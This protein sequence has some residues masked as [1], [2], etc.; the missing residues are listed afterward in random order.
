MPHIVLTEEQARILT[1]A[2]GPVE[3]LAPDGRP[4]ARAT[5]L[6]LEDMDDIDD[7]A[8]SRQSKADKGPRVPSAQVQAH[9]KR[10]EEIDRAEP[11][12]ETRA[13]ELLRRMR[14]GEEI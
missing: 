4:L 12:D 1:H 9:L 2:A 14:S 3:V 8:H 11:L 10:L 13:L 6:S 7:I 5:P